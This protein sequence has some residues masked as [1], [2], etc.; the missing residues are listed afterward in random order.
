MKLCTHHMIIPTQGEF[1]SMNVAHAAAVVAYE[2][3]KASCRPTGFQARPFRPADL[4]AREAM[5]EHVERVLT[6]AGFL[7]AANPLLM[8]RDLRRILNS[9]A[10]DERDVTILRGMF[11]KI[12]NMIRI[13]D[14]KIRKLESARSERETC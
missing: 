10:M 3:F 12:G 7:D 9:A 2:I 11:R 4:R 6:R 8:M 1:A 5:Y 14:E 13:A